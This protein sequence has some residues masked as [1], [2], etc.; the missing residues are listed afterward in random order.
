MELREF[1][2][3]ITEIVKNRGDYGDFFFYPYE[4]SYIYETEALFVTFYYGRDFVG[5]HGDLVNHTFSIKR[6]IY[7]NLST[8]GA[9]AVK[10]FEAIDEKGFLDEK[11]EV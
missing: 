10:I 5:G 8:P 3:K 6:V 2:A 11:G 4:F 1:I 9:E 7:P